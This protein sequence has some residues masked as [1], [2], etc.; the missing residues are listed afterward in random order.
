MAPSSGGAREGESA[1]ASAEPRSPGRGYSRSEERNAATRA[2]LEPLRQGE[3]PR[4]VT[5]GAVAAFLIA[6][7]NL[8]A[9]AA[10]LEVGGER[11][12]ITFVLAQSGLLL[13][14]A[15]GMWLVRYWAV[16]GMQAM[17]AILIVIFAVLLVVAN[18]VLAALISVAMIAAA[19]TLFWF[20]VKAMARI[21]MP[22]RR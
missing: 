3:R 12:A 7:A 18:N 13:I 6:V 5:L 17:L 15:W 21:Q 10:G 9:Y 16:L 14:A 19:G 11:P 20:L 1:P 22:E 2:A 4:A 8:I